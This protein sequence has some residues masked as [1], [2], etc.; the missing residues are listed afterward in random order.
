LF[1]FEKGAHSTATFAK[2]GL[3]RLAHLG[4]L[5]LDEVGDLTLDH[6]VKVLRALEDGMIRPVGVSM[7]SE[8]TSESWRLPTG[9]W[10]RWSKREPSGPICFHRLRAS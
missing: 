1:G 8:W 3:W 5:F 4:T 6:Q 10:G 9:R 2:Q 7:P